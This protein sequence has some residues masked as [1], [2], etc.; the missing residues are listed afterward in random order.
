MANDFR[1][2]LTQRELIPPKPSKHPLRNFDPEKLAVVMGDPRFQVDTQG[3]TSQEYGM[4]GTN[5]S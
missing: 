1:E 3:M 5:Q 2:V 4:F